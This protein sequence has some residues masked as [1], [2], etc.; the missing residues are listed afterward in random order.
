MRAMKRSQSMELKESELVKVRKD[1]HQDDSESAGASEY[2]F[3]SSDDSDST[4]GEGDSDCSD[5][6]DHDD[7]HDEALDL[8]VGTWNVAE[9]GLV[10]DA[11][12][13][14]RWLHRGHDLYVVGLQECVSAH[15]KQ[16]INGMVAYLDDGRRQYEVLKKDHLMNIVLVV[17]V[18]RLYLPRI[19]DVKTKTVACGKGNIIGNKGAVAMSFWFDETS[20][21][22]INV[23]LVARA[24][25][26]QQRMDNIDRIFKHLDSANMGSHAQMDALNQFDTVIFFGDLNYRIERDFYEVC[27]L[28]KEKKYAD[29][30]GSDQL[31]HQIKTNEILYSF[32]EGNISLIPPTYRWEK[33]RNVVS[34]KREQPP[35]YTDRILYKTQPNCYT[36]WQTK[37]KSVMRCF[38]SDHR[39]MVSHFKFVPRSF[40]RKR[41]KSGKRRRSKQIEIGLYELRAHFDTANSSKVRDL[42]H[43]DKISVS[44]HY[45]YS[46]DH[47][48]L[49]LSGQTLDGGT[50]FEA[51]KCWMWSIEQLDGI[52]IVP[53]MYLDPHFLVSTLV[54][55]QF[56]NSTKKQIIGY[57]VI[58]LFNVFPRSLV[59]REALRIKYNAQ[60]AGG[61]H[62]ETFPYH[63][64]DGLQGVGIMAT[65]NDES[66]TRRLK[67]R[68][69]LNDKEFNSPIT[70][71]GTYAGD[72]KGF[73]Y[74]QSEWIDKHRKTAAAK[75]AD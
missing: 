75:F 15:R 37:Y 57:S 54:Y 6:G 25:R 2:E 46:N 30:V 32:R 4:F 24:E 23:H 41:H 35:S 51:Q 60:F 43:S 14:G 48:G 17:I 73:I 63:L 59:D 44:F 55:L 42:E 8:W 28:M 5:D 19:R 53:P 12:V 47:D 62:P 9:S 3:T 61:Y 69:K 66:D 49:Q 31:N 67:M 39:P 11:D 56:T 20:F 33:H 26:F 34:N 72:V 21:L 74:A 71:H 50:W 36:M 1:R 10:L 68:R 45:N 18:N 70:I 65:R 7:A 27:G 40:P 38:G 13:L 16:W 64:N 58:S 29:F 22:L 52:K